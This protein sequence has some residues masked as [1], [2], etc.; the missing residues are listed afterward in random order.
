MTTL[1]DHDVT[2]V[3]RRPDARY[4]AECDPSIRSDAVYVL[5]TT[6]EATLAA[7]RVGHDFATAISVPLK[8]IHVRTVPYPLSVDSPTGVS[9]LET[10]EFLERLSAAGVDAEFHVVL[11]R[12]ERRAI[13]SAVPRHSL[14]VLAGPR[15]WWPTRPERWRRAL[16]S[17][18]HFVV[19]IDL[20]DPSNERPRFALR[21]NQSQES[22]HA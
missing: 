19:F 20:N 5:F 21:K 17:A 16:D 1:I 3:S 10:D 15:H 13:P 12:D 7:A 2:P 14:V 8:L 6:I 4:P 11:C 9:P 22:R 18:G